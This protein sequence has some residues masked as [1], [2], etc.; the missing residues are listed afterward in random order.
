MSSRDPHLSNTDNAA[1]FPATP[2]VLSSQVIQ[3]QGFTLNYFDH[4]PAAIEEYVPSQHLLRIMDTGAVY[5][6]WKASGSGGAA[7]LNQGEMIFCPAEVPARILWNHQAQFT[8]LQFDPTFI[9]QLID[10]T[11]GLER[12]D[13]TPNCQFFDSVIE[14]IVQ[15]LIIDLRE[16]S[17]MGRLYGDALGMALAVHLLRQSLGRPL[18][19][20]NYLDGLPEKARSRVLDFIEANLERD[21]RLEELAQ[22]SGLSRFYFSRLFKQ[23]MQLTP[24]QY[25][26]RRRVERAKQLLQRTQ[27]SIADIALECGFSSQS[28]LSYHF[29]RIVGVSPKAFRQQ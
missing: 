1:P 22:V 20:P 26:I 27:L 6:E 12:A 19:L 4:P 18:N 11:D 14:T 15:A 25:I 28:R 16:N 29:K 17:P 23:T 5:H 8:L 10:E 13:L 21:I 7:P 2:P 24:Y 9:Q 3:W